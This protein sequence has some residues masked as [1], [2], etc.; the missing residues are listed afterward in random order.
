MKCV[1]SEIINERISS[2][3]I[4]LRTSTQRLPILPKTFSS[5]Q[6]QQQS[7]KEKFFHEGEHSLIQK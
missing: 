5:D 4:T 7:K 1:D 2:G 6:Q 3:Q